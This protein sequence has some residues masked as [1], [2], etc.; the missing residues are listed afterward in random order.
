M[1]ALVLPMSNIYHAVYSKIQYNTILFYYNRRQTA[2]K[3]T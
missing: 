1:M 3:V 2:A